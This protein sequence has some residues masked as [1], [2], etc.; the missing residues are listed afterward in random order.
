MMAAFSLE[1][2]TLTKF[3][4]VMGGCV[5][6]YYIESKLYWIGMVSNILDCVFMF[7]D[8]QPMYD[9]SIL[10]CISMH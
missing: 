1:E 6:V 9:K 5:L 4:L 2:A 8:T 7:R 3:I 10:A